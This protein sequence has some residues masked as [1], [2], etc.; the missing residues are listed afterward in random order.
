MD[1]LEP[2]E[3]HSEDAATT[4]ELTTARLRSALERHV[5]ALVEEATARAAAIEDRARAK[6]NEI[7]EAA[8]RRANDVLK[9]SE[10]NTD[11]ALNTSIHRAEGML[12]GI[13]A[14]QTELGKVIGSF[15]DE[16]EGLVSE[17][18]AANE[19][20]SSP[21]RQPAL[22][23]YPT[24]APEQPAPEHS[25]PS[26]PSPPEPE[27][28]AQEP[29]PEPAGAEA[30]AEP[31]VQAESPLEQPQETAPEEQPAAQ[32]TSAPPSAPEVT[33]S[34]PAADDR[35]REA[36]RQHL[37]RLRDTGSPREEAE[38]YLKRF[39]N[40]DY[41]AILDDVYGPSEPAKPRRRGLLRRS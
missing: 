27:A 26:E 40:H 9:H 18:K 2:D 3:T 25:E 15:K 19:G 31:T 38:R 36:I 16:I 37:V 17:L 35:A 22:R 30:Q 7:E 10:R 4:T 11:D 5:H 29:L 6:A 21:S 12:E 28:S 1:Q 39:N 14:L 34:A 24:V 20:F 13:E 32:P 8:Q 23:G 33:E 41:D